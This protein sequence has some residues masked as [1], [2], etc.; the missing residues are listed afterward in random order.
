MA[1]RDIIK[2]GNVILRKQCRDVEKINRKIT[3]LIDDMIQ[4]MFES[5]GVGLAAPQVGILRKVAVI[6]NSKEEVEEFINPEIIASEGEQIGEEGCLSVDRKYCKVSRPM[7][8]TIKALDKQGKEFIK[9]YEGSDAVVCCHEFDHLRGVLY[10]DNEYK[11][12]EC[13]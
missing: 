7:K 8:I 1:I 10:Y 11:E 6:I 3:K 4:T 9:T 12:S 13:E 2:E 5:D